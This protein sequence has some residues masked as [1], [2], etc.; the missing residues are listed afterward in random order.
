MN[1]TGYQ[2]TA[3]LSAAKKSL[4]EI[5]L[6]YRSGK[7]EYNPYVLDAEI[8]VVDVQEAILVYN[9]SVVDEEGTRLSRYI[10]MRGVLSRAIALAQNSGYAALLKATKVRISTLNRVVVDVSVG[11]LGSKFLTEDSNEDHGS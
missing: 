11:K 8:A 7:T 9:S 3:G 1:V 4:D 2:L 10:K 5:T 6:L